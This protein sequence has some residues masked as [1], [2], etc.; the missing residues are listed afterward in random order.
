MVKLPRKQLLPACKRLC[1]SP[2][3]EEEAIG[4][5]VCEYH[6]I[7]VRVP[8]TCSLLRCSRVCSRRDVNKALKATDSKCF[9]LCEPHIVSVVSSL[10]VL[11]NI[12][13]M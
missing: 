5:S 2:S 1:W 4:P 9:R 6:C 3:Q 13:K 12:L 7:D 11:Y 8:W 10:F